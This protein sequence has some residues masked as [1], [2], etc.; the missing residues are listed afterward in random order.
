MQADAVTGNHSTDYCEA[1]LV[2][3]LFQ[4]KQGGMWQAVDVRF[5]L[6]ADISVDPQ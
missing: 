2:K 4:F 6:E 3:Y 1:A 5:W